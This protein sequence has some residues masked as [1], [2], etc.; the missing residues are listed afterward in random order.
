M[1]EFAKFCGLNK[2]H[3]ISDEI[4]AKSVFVDPTIPTATPFS[5]ILTL[6]TA[7]LIDPTLVHVLYGASKDFCANGLRLGFVYTRNKGIIGAMSSIR[8]SL[9]IPP[10]S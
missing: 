7:D 10:M 8:Y 3:L 6:D 1:K 4:Y 2:L 5:S 9:P